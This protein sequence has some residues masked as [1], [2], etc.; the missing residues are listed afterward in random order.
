MC[1]EWMGFARKKMIDGWWW[2]RG[3][4]GSKSFT[5]IP[6]IIMHLVYPEKFTSPPCS[7]P[8]GMTVKKMFQS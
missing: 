7:V 2:W 5:I 3:E 1:D 6:Y 8:L 4:G